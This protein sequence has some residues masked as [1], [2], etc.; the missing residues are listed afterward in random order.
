MS[1]QYIATPSID[2]DYGAHLHTY[3]WG[4]G[5]SRKEGHEHPEGVPMRAKYQCLHCDQSDPVA[6]RFP[7]LSHYAPPTFDSDWDAEK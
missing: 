4:P 3:C 6:G 2:P 5:V 1:D 7:P